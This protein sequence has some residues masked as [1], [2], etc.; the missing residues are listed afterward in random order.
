M[1]LLR[2]LVFVIP[3]LLW[4]VEAGSV[5]GEIEPTCTCTVGGCPSPPRQCSA[6]GNCQCVCDCVGGIASCDCGQ[7]S[8]F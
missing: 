2:V 4:G 1:R 6:S 8:G 7:G 5:G 3:M